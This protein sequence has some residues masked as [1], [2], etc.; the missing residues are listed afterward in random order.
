MSRWCEGSESRST[1]WPGID[2]CEY[3]GKMVR[4]RLDGT[5]AKHTM[6]VRG[7]ASD[8][9]KLREYD[10][11]VAT[12]DAYIHRLV[13]EYDLTLEV[14]E[15]SDPS[16]PMRATTYFIREKPWWGTHMMVQIR[17]GKVR[18]YSCTISTWAN[19][20]KDHEKWR[21][22]ASNMYNMLSVLHSVATKR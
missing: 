7:P 4:T 13:A 17:E 1:R 21:R 14:E 19:W 18:R 12:I 16:L 11:R 22:G 15:K 6:R 5:Y 8:E 9:P 3:C 10:R 2:Q 20:M